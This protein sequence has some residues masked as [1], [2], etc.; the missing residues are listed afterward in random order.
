MLSFKFFLFR[1]QL[2]SVFICK[3]QRTPHFLPN[4]P[5]SQWN[6]ILP[7]RIQW[8]SRICEHCPFEGVIHLY[9]KVY[10][11]K[12]L[13]PIDAYANLIAGVAYISGLS[14]I[15]WYWSNFLWSL[16]NRSTILGHRKWEFHDESWAHLPMAGGPEQA[17]EQLLRTEAESAMDFVWP[18]REDP[19]ASQWLWTSS[20]FILS[21]ISCKSS[22][23]RYWQKRPKKV[24]GE[25]SLFWFSLYMI[26][27]MLQ[28]HL[29]FT[30][31]NIRGTP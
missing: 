17:P 22:S 3:F 28:S 5:V 14:A 15:L 11:A 30:L 13:L 10:A 12:N 18:F 24:A 16:G 19:A 8:A 21:V 23:F 7:F 4:R 6:K 2:L 26:F 29:S 1:K 20:R 9:G 27:G 25:P 31:L